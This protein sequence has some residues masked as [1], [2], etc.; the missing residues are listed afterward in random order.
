[1]NKLIIK[2]I[3]KVI[4]GK[5]VFGDENSVL[6]NFSIN[7]KEIEKNGVFVGI[8]GENNDGSKYYLDAFEHNASGCILN[9]GFAKKEIKGKFV[10]EVDDT[11]LAL[12][13]LAKYKRDLYKDLLVIGVTGSVGKT[14]TKDIIASV[15]STKYKV[16]KT[17]GNYNNEI[18]LPLTIL[19]L[20]DEDA[21]VLEMGMSSLGEISLL[22]NLAR[23]KYGVITNVGTAHIGNL[24]SRENI[25]KAKL[26]ILEG[27]H[28]NGKL[29]INN[30]NDMLYNWN[31]EKKQD[32]VVTF[33]INNDSD[34]K[35]EDVL[36]GKETTFNCKGEEYK[37]LVGGEAFVYNA[38]SGISIGTLCNI[39]PKLIKKGIV[40]FQLTK[41]RLQII[42]CKDYTIIDD[43]YNANFDSMKEGLFNLS[44]MEGKRKIAVLG[45]MLEL[46]E[47]AEEL[48]RNVG[49]EVVKNNID[50]LVTIGKDANYIKEE[51][52]DSIETY[53]F[54]NNKDAINYLKKNISKGDTILIKA[55]NGMKF[56]EIVNS[57]KEK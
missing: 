20:E 3:L 25:L 6:E 45:D 40:D 12:Q 47:F 55:S 29:I 17:A 42:K 13:K 44:K 9:K 28:K 15:L 53:S 39:E 23:P 31:K 49:K 24:G 30:D 16:L 2:D 18:G 33:G 5:L 26:E 46:G 4:D 48:H 56:I 22:S 21:I 57:L 8:K 54:D 10:I 27:L 35:A 14:S 11:V 38:L 7:T 50:I 32:N 43:C 51:A 52:K 19:R 37:V 36:Y 41:D 34:Y 1:M